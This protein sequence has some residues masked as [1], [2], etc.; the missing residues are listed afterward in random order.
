MAEERSEALE[1]S[2]HNLEDL[3]AAA[4]RRL[5][6]GLHKLWWK[7]RI[8][9]NEALRTLGKVEAFTLAA[10]QGTFDSLD[11]VGHDTVEKW[12]ETHHDAILALAEGDRLRYLEVR[13]LADSP[14]L[15]TIELP[16]RLDVRDVDT[17]WASHIFVDKE[18]Q[19]PAS[20][21]KWETAVIKEELER[22]DFTAWSRNLPRK[23][24]SLC[25]P[26][27]MGG[28]WYG[29]YPDFLIVRHDGKGYRVD[30]VDPHGPD[31]AD[32]PYKA[33]WLA[34]YAAKHHPAFGR[35]EM[36]IVDK[37]GNIKRLDL[38]NSEVRK[39]VQIVQT[40]DQLKKLFSEA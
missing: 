32:A 36:A 23:H 21:N 2:A 11:Q 19:L 20:L 29:M 1:V 5:G 37:K 9:Q 18:G 25:V 28:R 27:E 15:T 24:W 6:E 4:G 10:D 34:N 31:Y 14:G 39:R 12:L 22:T 13:Q 3:F 17:R 16:H 30:I 8:S 38:K 7:T 26:Y 40:N 33:K 35:I